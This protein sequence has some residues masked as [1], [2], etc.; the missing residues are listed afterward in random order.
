MQAHTVR[1]CRCACRRV[2]VKKS[3]AV[4]LAEQQQKQQEGSDA[5]EEQKADKSVDPAEV[6]PPQTI[7]QCIKCFCIV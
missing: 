3:W 1:E 4:H 2:D 5:E 7:N 6:H